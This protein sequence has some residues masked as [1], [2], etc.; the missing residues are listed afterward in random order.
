MSISISAI[1]AIFLS[2]V[3]ILTA[4]GIATP[5]PLRRPKYSIIG[6]VTTLVRM[7]KTP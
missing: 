7:I 3:P 5:P 4:I 1:N 2:D 6:H